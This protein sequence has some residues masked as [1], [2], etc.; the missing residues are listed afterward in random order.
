M[1]FNYAYI[2]LASLPSSA[3]AHMC[4]SGLTNLRP[5]LLAHSSPGISGNSSFMSVVEKSPF[6]LSTVNS[7]AKLL[8]FRPQ[9]VTRSLSLAWICLPGSLGPQG[10][11]TGLTYDVRELSCYEIDLGIIIMNE[12]FCCFENCLRVIVMIFA[13]TNS[14]LWVKADL[15][16]PSLRS[17]LF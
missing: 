16:M 8:L 4:N 5:G 9:P 10:R 17:L 11:Q 3:P 15:F 1:L 12:N 2:K 14:H 7:S 6:L 13:H